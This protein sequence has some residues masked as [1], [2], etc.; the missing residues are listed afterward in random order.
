[1]AA[2]RRSH[3]GSAAAAKV[4]ALPSG[5]PAAAGTHVGKWVTVGDTNGFVV[6]NYGGG[7]YEVAWLEKQ[8]DGPWKATRSLGQFSP[9][10]WEPTTP[11]DG[12][13]LKVAEVKKQIRATDLLKQPAVVEYF[14]SYV[15]TEGQDKA[16]EGVTAQLE[17][18]LDT[19]A[20]ICTHE[21]FSEEDVKAINKT[22]G[23]VLA[24]L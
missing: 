10:K 3:G 2:V 9:D 14:Q 21:T 19:L 8:G 16:P 13:I 5:A 6:H 7:K 4:G 24:L 18:T 20:E 17:T 1:M 12:G 23:D 15:K 11:K 22:T